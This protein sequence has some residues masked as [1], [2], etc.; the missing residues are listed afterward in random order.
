MGPIEA[1]LEQRG[2][3]QSG[4][5]PVAVGDE[6]LEVHVARGDGIRVDHGNHVERL[7][8]SKPDRRLRRGQEHLKNC[9]EGGK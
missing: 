4:D 5:A 2:N 3:S 8:S 9:Q 6:I 1:H 7:H